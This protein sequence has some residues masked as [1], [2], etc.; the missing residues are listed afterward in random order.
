MPGPAPV[1]LRCMLL[2]PTELHDAVREVFNRVAQNPGAKFRFAVGPALARGVGYPE[3]DVGGVPPIVTESFTGVANPQPYL[4]IQ[5]GERVL[6]LGSGAGFDAIV[7][8]RAAGSTGHVTGLDMADA[9]IRK[10]RQAA[11]LLGVQNVT[12]QRGD[13]ERMPFADSTFDAALVNGIFN[14]CPDKPPVARELARVLR[15]GGRAVVAEMTF[16]DPLPSIEVASID[17]WFR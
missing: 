8:A 4:A 3:N 10:A 5:P 2:E 16:V 7:A 15:G 14:L 17:D 6:D 13:A 9:M 11:I 12:F 1:Y